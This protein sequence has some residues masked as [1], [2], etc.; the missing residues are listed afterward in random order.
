MKVFNVVVPW[1][2]MN[3]S[4]LFKTNS[5]SFGNVSITLL[6]SSWFLEFF[7]FFKSVQRRSRTCWRIDESTMFI[8]LKSVVE[9]L[10]A[11]ISTG[12]EGYKIRSLLSTLAVDK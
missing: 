4:S 12:F 6:K 9:D 2:S 3:K 7:D 11:E 1:S 5:S 10:S 8:C